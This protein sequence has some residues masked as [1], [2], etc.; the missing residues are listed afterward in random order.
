M[1]LARMSPTPRVTAIAAVIVK[2]TGIAS[3]QKST[4]TVMMTIMQAMGTHLAMNLATL[5]DRRPRATW[6]WPVKMLTKMSI[7][8]VTNDGLVT[9]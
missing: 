6:K 1:M 2:P 9:A 5:V 7:A 8:P 3:E 4:S